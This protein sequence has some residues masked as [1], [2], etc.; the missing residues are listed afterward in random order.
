MNKIKLFMALPSMGT[1]SDQQC[2]LLRALEAKYSDQIE[3]IYPAEFIGRIFHDFARNEY[4]K[5]FL[6]SDADI[7]WFLD[8]DVVPPDSILDLITIHGDKWKLSGAP[9]PVWIIPNGGDHKQA[10]FCAY[11]R[12]EKGMHAS[13]IPLSG[14][15]FVDGI[16]TG[17]IFVH[18][19][20]IE[21]MQEPYF[22]F[23]YDETSRC[24]SEGED[25]GFC[26]KASDLGYKFF[27]DFGMVCHHYKTVSL[28]EVNNYVVKMQQQAIYASDRAVRQVLAK[29]KLKSLE[30]KSNLIL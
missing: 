2:Y 4:T 1:R 18:R 22:E 15:D 24:I 16:A 25:L 27:V 11:R 19:E 26:R 17:C 9:Y 6:E 12:D 8:S 5:A 3:F 14:T 13:N 7:M 28:L 29:Q 10:V 20:V 21:K 30:I 23:K